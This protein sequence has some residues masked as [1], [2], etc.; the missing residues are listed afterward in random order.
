MRDNGFSKMPDVFARTWLPVLGGAETKCVVALIDQ[1]A[2]WQRE[3]VQLKIEEWMELTGMTRPTV[4]TALDN[5]VGRGCI[6]RRRGASREAYR[7]R[8]LKTQNLR[9]LPSKTEPE[10]QRALPLNVQDLH[11][12]ESKNLTALEVKNLNHAAVKKFNSGSA[13]P[14]ISFKNTHTHI[15]TTERV[16]LS[17]FS[18]E[19]RVEYA[20]AQTP[21][22]GKGWIFKSKNG[23]WD[24]DIREY[25][26]AKMRSEQARF[27]QRQELKAPAE[28]DRASADEVREMLKQ[29]TKKSG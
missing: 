4:I 10:K 12:S 5:L 8:L 27:Q 18:R 14:N 11:D 23:D 25:F 19:Q 26:A 15:Q 3:E 6:G 9:V 17:E 2:G 28:S 24:E 20:S 21:K 22:L 13:S 7:Y 1:T 16:C 29:A